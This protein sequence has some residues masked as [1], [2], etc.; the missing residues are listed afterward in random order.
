MWSSDGQ[1]PSPVALFSGDHARYHGLPYLSTLRWVMGGRLRTISSSCALSAVLNFWME[2]KTSSRSGM[3][4]VFRTLKAGSLLGKMV[5][6][7]I[8]NE[9]RIGSRIFLSS[10]LGAIAVDLGAA[11]AAIAVVVVVVIRDFFRCLRPPATA[12]YWLFG[13]VT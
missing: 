9:A 1:P 7:T 8:L 6:D 13:Y 11:A 5:C 2:V 3:M 12:F 10:F 4:G